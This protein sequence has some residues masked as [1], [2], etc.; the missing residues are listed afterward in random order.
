MAV[1]LVDAAINHSHLGETLIR[2]G[3]TTPD[4]IAIALHEQKK[5]GE[6]L[7]SILVRLGF[8]TEGIIRD[9]MGGIIGRQFVN[10]DN[11]IADSEAVALVPQHIARRHHVVPL[12]FDQGNRTLTVAMADTCNVIALDQITLHAGRDIRIISMLAG[13]GEIEKTI[14]RCY[15]FVLSIDGILHEIETD[16]IDYHSL[17]PGNQEYSHPVVRLVNAL[18]VDAVKYGASDIHFEPEEWFS[19]FRY[20]IDGILRQIRSVHRNYW[21]AIAVRIKV[22][23]G[24]DIAETRAPQDGRF[25]LSLSGRMVDFRASTFPTLHGEN[26]VL[27]I[28]DRQRC[29]VSLDQLDL[30]EDEAGFLQT[31]A[32]KPAGI[33]LVTG[34]TGSGKTTTLYAILNYLN[35]ESVH[36]MTLEDPV[37]YPTTLIRQTSVGP[38]LRL[39][40]ASGLRSLMRQDPDIILVGEIRDEDTAQMALRAAMT[41]HKVFTTLHTNSALGAIPRLYD[42]G[43]QPDVLAGNING[44]I[45]QRLVRR[46]CRKCKR[47]HVMTGKERA[48]L[49]VETHGD[50]KIIYRAA[51]CASCAGTGYHGRLAVV[52]ALCFDAALDEIVARRGAR[53]ELL[54]HA[55]TTGFRTLAQAGAARVLDGSTSMDEAARVIDLAHGMTGTVYH[56][57]LSI[58]GH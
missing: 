6:K 52:E 27:R 10:L 43:V 30:R 32:M 56:A 17:D 42:L 18:L 8:A 16:E 46:L 31:M 11:V 53:H 41:G 1:N 36:I 2:Q 14:D 23:A 21:P 50:E 47:A 54:C 3:I 29:I 38:G 15:G 7:G 35:S 13:A 20:R 55:V 25:S 19:R 4:Q 26:I 37:E 5:N 57:C 22:M 33:V 51:G 58:P 34:P 49:G 39:D 48:L 45:A 12:N 28:L 9:V 24:M 44:V 40:F